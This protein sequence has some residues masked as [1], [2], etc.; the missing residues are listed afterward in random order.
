MLNFNFPSLLVLVVVLSV[1]CQSLGIERV[2]N[3]YIEDR[4]GNIL[5]STSVLSL[6][7][8][9]NVICRVYRLQIDVYRT[10]S[11]IGEQ[12]ALLT[13]NPSLITLVR[14]EC[15]V[16]N[17]ERIEPTISRFYSHILCPCTMTILNLWNFKQIGITR[18]TT[19]EYQMSVSLL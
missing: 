11:C 3:V 5:V 19:K 17:V 2:L 7:V 12:P 16:N 8:E 9:R 1:F 15:R 4:G 13:L 14:A 18:K 6:Y 10:M